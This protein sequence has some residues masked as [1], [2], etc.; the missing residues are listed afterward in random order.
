MILAIKSEREA[1]VS[2]NERVREKKSLKAYLLLLHLGNHHDLFL[3]HHDLLLHHQ[4]ERFLEV[5][6]ERLV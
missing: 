6:E 4:S 2:E 3:L 1:S 5:E